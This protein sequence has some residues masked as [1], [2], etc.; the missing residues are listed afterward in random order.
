ME[1]KWPILWFD[2]LIDWIPFQSSSSS[3]GH[4]TISWPKQC[5]CRVRND[6]L[7]LMLFVADVVVDKKIIIILLK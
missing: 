2:Q 4:S 3:I 5:D 7:M 1:T 6:D